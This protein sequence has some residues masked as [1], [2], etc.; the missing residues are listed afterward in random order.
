MV[1][2]LVLETLKNVTMSPCL[3]Q[4][5]NNDKGLLFTDPDYCP[6]LNLYYDINITLNFIKF[7]WRL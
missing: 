5:E 2:F 7:P 1:A 6:F 4:T 3:K